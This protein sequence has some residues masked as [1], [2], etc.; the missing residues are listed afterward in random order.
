MRVLYVTQEMNPYT[1]LSEI[2]EIFKNLPQK[3]QDNNYEIRVLM[4][5]FGSI[6]ERRHRL[7]EV[8]RLSGMNIIVDDEDYPLIIK[9]ASIP[10]SRLQVYFLDNEEF[11]KKR[12]EFFDEENNLFEDN[13]ERAVFF[14]KGVIET[15]RKF[16]WAPDIIHCHG[17]FTSLVP[18]FVKK[19]YHTDP[20]L[21]FSKV[22]YS[23]YTD[24][25]GNAFKKSFKDV[26]T[27]NSL[28]DDDIT[29]YYRDGIVDLNQG[30]CHFADGVILASESLGTLDVDQLAKDKP[31]MSIV[32]NENHLSETI[33][34]YQQFI[35]QEVDNE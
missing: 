35:E 3:A 2:S 13:E 15:V 10:G 28:T 9:V 25:I 32:G 14:C 24:V 27:I 23:A 16:G 26:A 34:F 20:I 31:V 17:S 4:P 21:N 8:V 19:V 30:A 11:F 5:K 6:N 1:A 7:H 33:A 29:A 22:I 18:L 12:A